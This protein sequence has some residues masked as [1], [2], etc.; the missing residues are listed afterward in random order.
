MTKLEVIRANKKAYAKLV[1]EIKTMEGLEK[2]VA[3]TLT[4]EWITSNKFMG[5]LSDSKAQK[6]LEKIERMGYRM[7]DAMNEFDR[8]MAKF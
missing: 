8:Q 5:G 1:E 6:L 4:T 3:E 2:L 7:E